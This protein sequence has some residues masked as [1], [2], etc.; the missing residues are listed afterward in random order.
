M[1]DPEHDLLA[2]R[3]RQDG[4]AEVDRIAVVADRDAAVLGV[5]AVGDVELAHDL[6]AARDRRRQAGRHLGDLPHDAVDP[7][8][9]DHRVRLRLE[10]DVGSALGDR[11]GDDLVRQLD[12]GRV[13][14]VA[15]GDVLAGRILLQVR[16]HLDVD[17]AAEA[18]VE[19]AREVEGRDDDEA[20]LKPQR[21]PEVVGGHHVGRVGD[22]DD[23]GSVL[24]QSDRQRGE[25]SR[26]VLG[27]EARRGGDEVEAAQ[28]E[29]LEAVLLGEGLCDRRGGRDVVAEQDLAEPAALGLLLGE[30]GRELLGGD[31]AVAQE[32]RAELRPAFGPVVRFRRRRRGN[33]R[34]FHRSS[35]GHS[36]G[37]HEGRDPTRLPG[38]RAGRRRRRRRDRRRTARP[39]RCGVR[40]RG[41]RGGDGWP[42]RSPASGSSRTTTAASTVR[43]STRAAPSS[44]SASSR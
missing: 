6:Q 2:E 5:A 11:V 29:E 7:G 26:D 15:L 30:R 1:E 31:D 3:R 35:I 37:R 41:E 8:A 10:V 44:P 20:D 32:Q 22:R 12:R 19:R 43:C 42:R 24:V 14:G 28:L 16:L 23:H 34:S 4:D 27:Q 13:G 21:E 25:A 38:L 17:V 33:C 18:A 9:D 36:A 39:A 40:R